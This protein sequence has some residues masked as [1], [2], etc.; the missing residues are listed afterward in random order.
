[1]TFAS[2]ASTYSGLVLVNAADNAV[3]F[4]A[5]LTAEGIF[6][7]TPIT[8]NS[9]HTPAD[10]FTVVTENNGVETAGVDFTVTVR[11]FDAYGNI[12][13][14][15]VNDY[16]GLHDIEFN[17]TATASPNM[18][19]PRVPD[20]IALTFAGGVVTTNVVTD[21][22]ALVNAEEA[23][24]I[25]AVDY[26]A[27]L[28]SGYSNP[29][30]VDVNPAVASVWINE[31]VSGDRAEVRTNT[32]T[33]DDSYVVHGSRYDAYGN[34]IGE[35]PATAVWDATGDYDAGDIVGT[36]G[37]SISF[38]P[39]NTGTV[40]TITI[41]DPYNGVGVDDTTGYITV[42]VGVL[43]YIV[44]KDAAGGAGSEVTT[45]VVTADDTIQV[46]AAGYDAD[47]NYVGD[48]S[49][50]WAT[51]GSLDPTP[52][53]P[54]TSTVFTPTLAP[55]SGTITADDGSGHT[56]STG[57]ITVNGSAGII[58][59][60]ISGDTTEASVQ[61]TFTVVLNSEPTNDVYVGLSSN[62]TTE[63]TVSPASLTF[64]NANWNAPQT[65]T[66]TGVDDAVLD[67]NQPYL[68]ITAPAVSFD[69][70]YNGIDPSDPSLINV[71]NDNFVG[72]NVS[73]ISGDTTE[74]GGEATFTIVLNSPPTTAVTV[75][76]SSNDF[77]EGTV[78]PSS[79]IFTTVN[80]GSPRIITVTGVEDLLVDGN[81]PFHI[82]TDPAVS[83]DTNYSGLDAANVSV[84]N[85]D[86]DMPGITVDAVSGDT[87]ES[88]GI[89]TFSIILNSPPTGDVT[90]VLSSSDTTEGTIDLS[91]VT[92]TPVNWNVPK[93]VTVT[94]VD[95]TV[96]DGNQLYFIV[97][98]PAA[99]VDT[100]YCIVS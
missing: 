71:D 59:G 89:V 29:I 81:Q 15:G 93:T 67:G 41:D 88:G 80:W 70:N 33:T 8:I 31:G 91:S 20:S 24:M 3:E 40:G 75:G 50:T 83:T 86:D 32:M 66:V 28:V 56:D 97:T 73:A 90:I 57:T 35:V 65:V 62:D 61:A 11:A 39:D 94:G 92:F 69:A 63:G 76:I 22:F 37:V 17:S 18:T 38:E 49:V 60:P 30:T 7:D 58:G 23:V 68:I 19:I 77:S 54:A 52:A 16:D 72:I 44:I 27:P 9:D 47:N 34:F 26:L 25:T 74:S 87:S 4:R 46:W 82:I 100:D 55:T 42:N 51:T 6:E 48:I 13:E 99:S 5:R 84:V 2:G 85:F 53:G 1:M 64:T 45:L 21:P 96:L 98:D 10:Y 43:D 79:V 78:S 95:D 36:P 12:A 14:E